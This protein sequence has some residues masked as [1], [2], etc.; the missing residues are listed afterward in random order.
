[1]CGTGSVS[2]CQ[3]QYSQSWS[4][5]DCQVQDQDQDH[6]H[7]ATVRVWAM[8]TVTV[9]VAVKGQGSVPECQEGRCQGY[10]QD[11]GEGVA[12]VRMK[13]RV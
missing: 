2:K 7:G 9:T 3:G 4:V 1:M 11:Q 12:K 6:G 10:G 8:V 13:I 5:P